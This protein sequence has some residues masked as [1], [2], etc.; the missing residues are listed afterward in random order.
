M[1]NAQLELSFGTRYA[2]PKPLATPRSSF[3]S[4]QWWF[5]RMRQIVDCAMDWRPAPPP[6][7]EQILFSG[8]DHRFWTA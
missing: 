4:A 2:R 6:R 1:T 5:Q 8:E 3:R 7:P